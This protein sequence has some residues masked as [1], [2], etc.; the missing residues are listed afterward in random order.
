MAF[1]LGS[2]GFTVVGNSVIAENF[3]KLLTGLR[4]PNEQVAIIF[5]FVDE[6][7]AWNNQPYVSLDDYRIS[8]DRF[9]V[10]EK[11]FCCEFR[12]AETPARVLIA[13]RNASASRNIQRTINKS[14]R[15]LHTHGGK[16]YLHHLKRFIFYVYM[17]F[18]ELMLLKKHS[19]LAHCS[20]VERDGRCIL[21][22]AWGGVG[23]TSIMSL[24]LDKGWKFLSDDSCVIAADGSVA[25]HPL[26]MHI[27]KYHEVQSPELVSKMLSRLAPA[28][29]FLWHT[30]GKMKKPDRLVRWI[31]AETVFGKESIS[32]GGSVSAVIHMHRQ[33]NCSQFT[34]AK[35]DAERV[36]RLMASTILDEINNLANMAIVLHSF[37][38]NDFVPDI[39]QVHRQLVEIY[40]TAFAKAN[41][42][43]ISIPTEAKG[44]D[45]YAYLCD[46]KL[47]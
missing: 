31:G 34:L 47:L 21:F 15:Y 4:T 35:V 16:A 39:E 44:S 5:E 18:I 11:L 14:W 13:P 42:Y 24:C 37:K 41:C 12:H 1:T 9:R 26:P 46:K 6:L 20:A 25:I 40:S 30:L 43:T 45:T 29:R 22:S 32:A 17:P 38:S 23:K 19:T 2:V 28:S 8:N 3:K 33:M 36:A 7:P 27:Y 10:S